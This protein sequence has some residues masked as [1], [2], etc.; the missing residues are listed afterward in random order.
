M[1]VPPII[2]TTTDIGL[3]KAPPDGEVG[4]PHAR[5][6]SRGVG[7]MGQDED[8][9]VGGAGDGGGGDAEKGDPPS[10]KNVEEGLFNNTTPSSKNTSTDSLSGESES[11]SDSDN[12]SSD[13]NGLVEVAG[14]V[15]AEAEEVK[16]ARRRF[17]RNRYIFNTVD[18]QGGGF[19]LFVY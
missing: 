12:S 2:E 15:P 18:G 14:P 6:V 4:S 3:K 7:K 1:T 10:P 5:A 19:R 13:S 8:G 9:K 11:S 16:K 17:Q